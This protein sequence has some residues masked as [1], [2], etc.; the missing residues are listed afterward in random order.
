M[1]ENSKA[2]NSKRS[3]VKNTKATTANN[4]PQQPNKRCGGKSCKSTKAC[5]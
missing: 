4:E 1:R 3:S 2:T 5:K